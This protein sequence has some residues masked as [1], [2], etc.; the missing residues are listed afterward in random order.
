MTGE[1]EREE[2]GQMSEPGEK[3]GAE[4]PVVEAMSLRRSGL[5]AGYDSK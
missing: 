1:A 5:I 4:L 2:S 3:T